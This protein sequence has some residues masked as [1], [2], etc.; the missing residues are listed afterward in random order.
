MSKWREIWKESVAANRKYFFN[1]TEGEKVFA[2]LFNKYGKDEGMIHYAYGE[3]FLSQGMSEEAKEEFKKAKEFFPV[4]HW[5][6]VARKTVDMISE[7]KTPEKY[8]NQHKFNDYLWFIF[9]KIYDFVYL[10]DFVRYVC[11]SAIS[12]ASSEWP[13]SLIDFRTILELKVN[14]LLPDYGEDN[15]YN[16]DLRSDIDE[17][18]YSGII[19]DPSIIKA[20]H[21]IRKNG[22]KATHN[23]SGVKKISELNDLEMRDELKKLE[24]FYIVIKYLNDMKKTISRHM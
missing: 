20:M 1:R 23:I 2:E 10:D 9:Q 7:G 12:R 19:T 21:W 6:E 16:K 8:Y 4:P 17:L 15:W 14:E 3:A 22:N 18:D 5:K 11:L 13:L 24:N